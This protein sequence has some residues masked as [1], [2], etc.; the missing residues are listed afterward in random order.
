M[1]TI[2]VQWRKTLPDD[3]YDQEMRVMASGH[4]RFVPGSRFDFGFFQIA[5]NEGY[6]I[7]SLPYENN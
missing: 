2:V 5:T 3:L 6:T 7:I 4:P 1:K